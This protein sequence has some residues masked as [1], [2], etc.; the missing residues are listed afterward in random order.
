[1]WQS[2]S[3]VFPPACIHP[4]IQAGEDGWAELVAD[5][6]VQSVVEKKAWAGN[7]TGKMSSRH[8]AVGQMVNRL[9][10]GEHCA[11]VKLAGDENIYIE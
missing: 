9:K 1:M 6:E 11:E 2:S 4:F 3:S 5:T 8:E 10:A 7:Q